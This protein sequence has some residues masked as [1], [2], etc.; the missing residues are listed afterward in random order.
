MIEEER[1]IYPQLKYYRKMYNKN[2]EFTLK[3]KERSLDYYNSIREYQLKKYEEDEE[4]RK[5]RA[6]IA[7]KCYLKRKAK[8]ALEEEAKKALEEVH[9]AEN[10]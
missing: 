4:Y 7:R 8:K 3:K 10:S 6:E 5:R 1:K 2:E 9:I